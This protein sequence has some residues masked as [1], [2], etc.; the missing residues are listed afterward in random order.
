MGAFEDFFG[1]PLAL[2]AFACGFQ[3]FFY[4]LSEGI[5][6]LC[7]GDKGGGVVCGD[8]GGEDAGANVCYFARRHGEV[9]ITSYELRIVCYEFAGV[10]FLPDGTEEVAK[11]GIA[12]YVLGFDG[13]VVGVFCGAYGVNGEVD[14]AFCGAGDFDAIAVFKEGF[15]RL[16][17]GE[18]GAAGEEAV[19]RLAVVHGGCA[20]VHGGG[21]RRLRGG[22]H[23]H[24]PVLRRRRRVRGGV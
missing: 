10:E 11:L 15:N 13:G 17:V 1:Y 12:R 16:E 22:S 18:D 23:L 21:I 3:N 20:H 7:W 2:L 9:R 4:E 19:P 5:C 14:F 6:Q 8:N 24:H